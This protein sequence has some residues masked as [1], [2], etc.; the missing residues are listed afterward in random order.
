ML[1][2]GWVADLSVGLSVSHY[3]S[4]LRNCKTKRLKYSWFNQ[5]PVTQHF[6]QLHWNLQ[7]PTHQSVI[8]MYVGYHRLEDAAL[9][10]TTTAWCTMAFIYI[11]TQICA[12]CPRADQTP[13]QTFIYAHIHELNGENIWRCRVRATIS[14]C[15]KVQQL[16]FYIYLCT[17]EWN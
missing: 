2:E 5:N 11:W 16:P 1:Y 13:L 17:I 6:T 14:S 15:C 9:I 10:S 3:L 8:I 7:N 12:G 4:L